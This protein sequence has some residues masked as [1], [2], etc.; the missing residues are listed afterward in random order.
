M[1]MSF[2][3]RHNIRELDTLDQMASIVG[4]MD[5]KTL[6]YKELVGEL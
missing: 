2:V 1:S 3:A 5:G 4:Q 6:P